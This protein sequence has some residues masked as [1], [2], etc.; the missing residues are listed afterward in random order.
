MPNIRFLW[1]HLRKKPEE[2]E[3][4]KEFED[5]LSTLAEDQKNSE[6][7]SSSLKNALSR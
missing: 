2:H 3:K 7:E 4:L 6:F 1:Q 5:F